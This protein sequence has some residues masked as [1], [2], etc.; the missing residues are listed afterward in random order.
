MLATEALQRI[1][2]AAKRFLLALPPVYYTVP[3]G[4]DY[5]GS[6]R[7]WLMRREGHTITQATL[8][9]KSEKTERE[10][11]VLLTAELCELLDAVAA[12]S[13]GNA[14]G[15]WLRMAIAGKLQADRVDRCAPAA[16]WARGE[17]VDDPATATQ[18]DA[19]PSGALPPQAARNP[20]ETTPM[21]RD[22]FNQA[23][24]DIPESYWANVSK[25]DGSPSLFKSLMASAKAAASAADQRWGRLQKVEAEVRAVLANVP[26]AYRVESREGGAF[27]DVCSSLA[28]SVAKVSNE[29]E[30]VRKTVGELRASQI[31]AINVRAVDVTPTG[32]AIEVVTQTGASVRDTVLLAM[33][34]MIAKM[35][36]ATVTYMR[37]DSGAAEL[38]AAV[39]RQ[40]AEL[41]ELRQPAADGPAVRG[42]ANS[43]A[44]AE[45]VQAQLGILTDVQRAALKEQLADSYR[46][47]DGAEKRGRLLVMRPVRVMIEDAPGEFPR[48]NVRVVMGDGTGDPAADVV[49][50][51]VTLARAEQMRVEPTPGVWL[52]IEHDPKAPDRVMPPANYSQDNWIA[53][54]R[55]RDR[56]V[57][58]LSDLRAAA[59]QIKAERERL[60]ASLDDTVAALRDIAKAV[61]GKVQP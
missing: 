27:E 58:E 45:A 4:V 12:G 52:V 7:K 28:I 36:A 14:V 26:K 3:N 24:S 38:Q 37:D 56:L 57:R 8:M 44:T 55:E 10:P 21:T 22:E 5:D 43:I 47:P 54:V 1:D 6:L 9:S 34:G 46:R 16:E 40:S 18:T 59:D 39:K 20:T 31:V 30:A 2:R 51:P 32:V 33:P 49:S 17:L 61:A 11:S 41:H 35:G 29:L 23:M 42:M 53:V 13:R 19:V 60:R 25:G 15:T 50:D 48:L